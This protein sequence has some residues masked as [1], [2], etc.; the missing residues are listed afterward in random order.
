MARRGRPV[1]VESLVKQITALLLQ[2][3]RAVAGQSGKTAPSTSVAKPTKGKRGRPKG[4]KN[5]KVG[6]PKG[7][8]NAN[9]RQ[10]GQKKRGPGRPKGSKKKGP[11]RPKGSKNKPKGKRGRPK[12]G[13]KPLTQL[14]LDGIALMKTEALKKQALDL[15]HTAIE[16]VRVASPR[17][18]KAKLAEIAEMDGRTARKERRLIVT[19]EE[20]AL[21]IKMKDEGCPTKALCAI[22]HVDNKELT[23]ALKS[24][25]VK[26]D[27]P[28]KKTEKK[29]IKKT[30]KATGHKKTKKADSNSTRPATIQAPPPAKDSAS[31]PASDANAAPAGNAKD[32]AAASPEQTETATQPAQ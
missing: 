12:G 21:M 13:R 23:A 1:S 29:A 11:G 19:P 28:D 9:L 16:G 26:L 30:K 25:P 15:Y 22:F 31:V 4:S 20:Q 17:K 32:T 6:R 7:S 5:K 24:K 27:V 2:L 10:K 18:I 8:T 14:V 3:V